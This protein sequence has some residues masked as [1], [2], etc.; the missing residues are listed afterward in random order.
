MGPLRWSRGDPS[1]LFPSCL[2]ATLLGW[3]SEW[4]RSSKSYSHTNCSQLGASMTRTLITNHHWLLHCC[5]EECWS[6]CLM[7]TLIRVTLMSHRS[8]S[9]WL[10]QD[11]PEGALQGQVCC[12]RG[13]LHLWCKSERCRK[14]LTDDWQQVIWQSS[15][16]LRHV[17][18]PP[19]MVWLTV[20]LNLTIGCPCTM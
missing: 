15:V 19:A 1:C 10:W 7:L 6:V 5:N 18:R 13:A 2:K 4:L 12:R 11:L 16:H 8:V 14:W 3:E 17:V 9:W 20:Q